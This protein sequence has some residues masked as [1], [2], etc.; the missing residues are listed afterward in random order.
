LARNVRALGRVDFDE[1]LV[2]RLH[3][4]TEGWIEELRI[5]K[6]GETVKNDDIL[7]SIYSPRLVTGQEEYLLAMKNLDLANASNSE[8]AVRNARDVV[9]ASRERLESLDVP[10]HQI[11]ELEESKKVKRVL[12]IH[13]P[14]EGVVMHVGSRVGQYVTPKTE[15]YMIA[16]LSKVWVLVDVYEYELPWIQINDE[17]EMRVTAVPG[18]I[19][20]GQ[21]TYIYPYM[22]AKT[23]TVKVRL[24][25]DNSEGLLKPEMFANITIMAERRIDA[26]VVPSEAIVRSGTG[27]QI[28][29]VRGSGKFEP[30]SVTLGVSS[31]GFTQVLSGVDS[32]EEV[33]TSA[34]FLIDSE[35]KL[36]EATAKMMESLNPQG[37]KVED[38]QMDDMQ[39][40]DMQMDDMQMDRNHD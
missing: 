11:R 34:Q 27:E 8:R 30:R 15:L 25:Y 21:I 31:D 3:P 40:D 39:M 12:H 2:T 7:L 35:S 32:G 4:K 29:V 5:N 17:A 13:S 19:F 1:E 20:R 6:T 23:R 24:E 33:L 22:E 36:K 37:E 16:D 14:F 28:F 38:M 18:R 26:M 9:S 10:A